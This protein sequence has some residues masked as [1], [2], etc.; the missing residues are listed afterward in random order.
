[1]APNR[2]LQLIMSRSDQSLSAARTTPP[3][4]RGRP[5]KFDRPAQMVALTLPEDVIEGLRRIDNDLAWAIVTLFQKEKGRH[6][7]DAKPEPD[8]ELAKIAERRSLIVI[9]RFVFKDLPGVHMVPLAGHRAFLALEP[10]KGMSDLELAVVDRLESQDAGPAER[11]A[12]HGLR[13]QL[14]QWR[15]DPEIRFHT[16]AIIIVERVKPRRGRGARK[17][18]TTNIGV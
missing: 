15:R 7:H 17:P 12:L 3:R 2:I 14:R 5:P 1:L 4:R 8:A 9:N 16:R 13:L 6:G 18:A 10:G 11:T